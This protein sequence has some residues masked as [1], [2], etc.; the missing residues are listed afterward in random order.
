MVIGRRLA[1]CNWVAG[2]KEQYFGRLIF[3][4]SPSYWPR[5]PL[6]YYLQNC[7]KAHQ[8]TSIWKSFAGS[9]IAGNLIPQRLRPHLTWFWTVPGT[10]GFDSVRCQALQDLILWGVKSCRIW[11]SEVSRPLWSDSVRCQALQYLILL[12]LWGI[13][14]CGIRFGGGVGL[15]SH[16]I[17][18]PRL[19]VLL[20][21]VRKR[22]LGGL[23]H[24]ESDSLESQAPPPPSGFSRIDS[25]FE[26]NFRGESGGGNLWDNM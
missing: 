24:A 2:L 9:E 7:F 8:G 13:R 17:S 19:E 3:Y 16:G 4:Q 11:F 5:F 6:L 10:T 22:T 15:I 20:M 1:D 18:S 14:P 26:K 12:I 25:K 21:T 23:R